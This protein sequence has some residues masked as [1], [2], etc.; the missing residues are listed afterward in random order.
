MS[1]IVNANGN[2]HRDWEA[3]RGEVSGGLRYA[4]TR[5]NTN[6]G[7]LLEVASFAYAAIELLAEQ[8]LLQVEELDARKQAVAGRLVEKFADQ[9]MGVVYQNPEHEKYGFAGE[10]RID[11][12]NRLHL[13]KAA[14][15]RLRFALSKQDVEEGIVKWDFARPYLIARGPDGYCQHVDRNTLGCSIHAHRPVPCRAFDCRKDERIWADFERKIINPRINDP[16]WPQGIDGVAGTG[17]Q[18]QPQAAAQLREKHRADRFHRPATEKVLETAG[19][20]LQRFTSSPI[21]F[22]F[23]GRFI[24]SYGLF[25]SLGFGLGILYWLYLAAYRFQYPLPPATVLFGLVFAA[26]AGSRLVF[27][28]E[29]ELALWLNQSAICTRGHSLYGG[30]LG[31]LVYTLFLYR[32]DLPGLFFLLDSAAPAMALGYAIGKIGCLSYGCCIGRP[33][34]SRLSVHYRS[35]VSKAVGYYELKNVPLLPIQFFE[36]IWGLALFALLNLQSAASFG[37]G[38]VLGLFLLLFGLGRA[39]LFGY[40]Y[41]FPDERA[42]LVVFWALNL[43]FMTLGILL[44]GRTGLSLPA[45]APYDLVVTGQGLSLPWL[46]L[47]PAGITAL[48]LLLF[49]IQR[50]ET[51]N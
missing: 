11:C 37:T 15:C 20:L 44:S 47:L 25:L 6:T 29:R 22:R 48:V 23:G 17:A 51:E 46:L 1:K 24:M 39:F 12:E 2:E 26:F 14:C 30:I 32:A 8:G 36:T 45:P 41:R 35:G 33:T 42:N 27:I 31:S 40:R 19:R 5:A 16:G 9:G 7:K 43:V 3:L 13:C 18:G 4:H 28:A 38:Q 10:V 49:G 50:L 21:L 34:R